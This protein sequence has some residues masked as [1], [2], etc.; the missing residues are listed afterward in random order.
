MSKPATASRPLTGYALTNHFRKLRLGHTFTP[1]EA[2]LFFE[3][4]A[5][6]NDVGW[7]EEFSVSNALLQGA[8][9]CSEQGLINARTSLARAGLLVYVSGNRRTPT[10]YRFTVPQGSTQ[11]S[12]LEP[13]DEVQDSTKFSQS[14]A[15][16]SSEGSTQ[17]NHL[18]QKAANGSTQGSSEGSTQFS[19][20]YK[21]QTKSKTLS[22]GEGASTQLLASSASEE[23]ASQPVG[24]P[25][26]EPAPAKA[27]DTQP[28]ASRAPRK[29]G[30]ITPTGP[31]ELLPASCPLAELLNPGGLAAKVQQLAEPLTLA[32]AER[33]LAEYNLPALRTIFC[34]MANWPKLLTSSTSANLTA[35]NWLNKRPRATTAPDPAS[36]TITTS[37]TAEEELDEA[38][39]Q[40]RAEQE[41]KR[42]A[43]QNAHFAR[44]ANRPTA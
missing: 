32:Q 40:F 4:A 44:W 13:T 14:P 7:P 33:L 30:A 10:L 12:Q 34:E 6:C 11:F 36:P 25:T 24:E 31:A 17:F 37:V 28:R 26:S 9:S 41:E 5:C 1:L 35:R 29:R 39:R 2:Y 16:G 8:L 42:L 27:A 15:D 23:F 38:A 18:G 21:E 22:E 43:Q 3:L 19:P 20:L